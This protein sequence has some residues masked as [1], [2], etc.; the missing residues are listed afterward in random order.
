MPT[1]IKIEGFIESSSVIQRRLILATDGFERSG[2][3]HFALTM[4]GTVAVINLDTGTDELV[5]KFKK[6]GKSVLVPKDDFTFKPGG[7]KGDYEKLWNKVESC[8]MRCL[9]VKGLGGM[10]IDTGTQLSQLKRLAAFGKLTQ[11]MPHH[12]AQPN[13]EFRAL[14]RSIYDS[15]VNCVIAHKLKKKYVGSKKEPGKESWSGDY[16]RDGMNDVGY[17][18]QAN[19]RNGFDPETKTFYLKVTDCRH[20]MDLA[21]VTIGTG[22]NGAGEACDFDMEPTFENVLEIVY[23]D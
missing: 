9:D 14:I 19:V 22:G 12:Y 16:E 15:E 10:F 20:N 13:E 11:V 18:V 7:M 5:R 17:L 21:G 8:I 2:K 23:A 3:S 6:A 1:E 4:P